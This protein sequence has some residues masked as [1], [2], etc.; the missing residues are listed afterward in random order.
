MIRYL[1][2]L[3]ALF[4]VVTVA[5]NAVADFTYGANSSLTLSV[6]NEATNVEAGY[7][8]GLIGVDF[9]LNQEN[10]I[11]GTV[12]VSDLGAGVALYSATSAWQTFVGTT[13][14]TAP[15]IS[16]RNIASQQN[17]CRDIW[18]N[19]GDVSPASVAA[20]G[21]KTANTYFADGSYA[22]FV[23]GNGGQPALAPLTTESHI[24]IYLYQYD[25]GTLNKGLLDPSSDYAAVIRIT[26]GG[27]VVLNPAPVDTDNDGLSDEQE[28][29]MCTL[30]NDADSDDDGITDG[31]EDANH[32][33][34]VDDG[35]TDPCD[36]D[37]DDDGLQD[38]TE[39]GITA[40]DV[41]PDTNLTVFIEDA[42]P[43]TRTDPLDGDSDDDGISDGEEDSNHNGALDDGE[44]DPIVS[45]RPKLPFLNL[46]L[47]D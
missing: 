37:S 5:G 1:V 24:D 47:L 10:L 9:T 19:Y 18:L 6:F 14:E 43:D 34:T 44:T 11:L 22:N 36:M 2:G 28:A 31:A 21:L 27:S 20:S 26:D 33:G 42:D 4:L 13:V 15:L 7:D 40:N 25:G 12:D 41:G 46:L 35:E 30:F 16:T 39:I 32:N 3:A 17:A 29:A 8:L 38:G 23:T 45:N